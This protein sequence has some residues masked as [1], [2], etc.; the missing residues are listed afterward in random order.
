MLLSLAERF[1][2]SSQARAER[3]RSAGIST[4]ESVGSGRHDTWAAAWTSLAHSFPVVCGPGIQQAFQG[5]VTDIQSSGGLSSRDIAAVKAL[6]NSSKTFGETFS[7][8]KLGRPGFQPPKSVRYLIPDDTYASRCLSILRRYCLSRM[9]G[10]SSWQLGEP[11]AIIRR[12][13]TEQEEVP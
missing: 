2:R 4:D 10:R 11:T 7:G 8:P 1:C 3:S 5:G 12:L 9:W 13:G 6:Q